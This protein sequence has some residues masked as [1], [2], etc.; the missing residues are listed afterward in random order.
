MMKISHRARQDFDFFVET[1]LDMI[2]QVFADARDDPNG[3]SALECWFERDTH[4]KVLPCRE[5]ELLNKVERAKQSWNLQIKLWAEDV[6][7]CL[8]S[9]EELNRYCAGL[10][11]WIIQATIRQAGKI[12]R[13]RIGFVPRFIA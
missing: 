5:I 2:G 13:T 6:A 3:F 12:L 10:P 8:L 7:G 9:K 4:G 1:D 11:S